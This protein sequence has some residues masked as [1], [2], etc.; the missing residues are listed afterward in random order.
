MK[1]AATR[2]ASSNRRSRPFRAL[3]LI[4]LFLTLQL[5]ASSGPLHKALHHNADSAS[6]QCVITLLSHGQVN[7]PV[8]LGIWLAFATTLIFSLPLLQAIVQ[9]SSDL[10]LAPGRAP[11]RF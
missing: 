4:A 5:F 6:H 3:L 1:S 10:R 11:P 8:V 9:S 2:I 7:V